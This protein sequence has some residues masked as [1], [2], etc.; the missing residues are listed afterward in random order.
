[1]DPWGIIKKSASFLVS[2]LGIA[3]FVLPGVGRGRRGRDTVA[4]RKAASRGVATR[5]FDF[6]EFLGTIGFFKLGLKRFRGF[7]EFLSF[8][9]F[10]RSQGFNGL[11]GFF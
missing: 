9:T 6:L 4:A 7:T 5:V 3:F 1:M 11:M 8:A 10:L 2:F